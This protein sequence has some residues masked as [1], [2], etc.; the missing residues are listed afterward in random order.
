ME[1]PKSEAE[2]RTPDG[3]IRLSAEQGQQLLNG[4]LKSLMI[5][6]SEIS[7]E[8]FLS[9]EI[10]HIRQDLFHD[11]HFQMKTEWPEETM[12]PTMSM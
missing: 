5:G 11:E 12:S 10:T 1:C 4:T 8:D 6:G 7:A 9:Q 3:D 2:I